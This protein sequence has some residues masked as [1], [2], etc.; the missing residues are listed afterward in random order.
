MSSNFDNKYEQ[1]KEWKGSS[2]V[3]LGE[4]GKKLYYEKFRRNKK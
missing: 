2:G 1:Q 4:G 3:E